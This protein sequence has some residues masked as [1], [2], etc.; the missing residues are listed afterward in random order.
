M[1]YV[2]NTCR[3]PT[4]SV[5]MLALLSIVPMLFKEGED[6]EYLNEEFF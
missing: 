4:I 6:A 3:V 2:P 5:F 1:S